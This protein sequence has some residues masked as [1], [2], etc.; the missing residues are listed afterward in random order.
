MDEWSYAQH[1]SELKLHNRDKK[2]FFGR[3]MFPLSRFINIEDLS[4]KV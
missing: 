1:A 4:Q 2:I 3:T